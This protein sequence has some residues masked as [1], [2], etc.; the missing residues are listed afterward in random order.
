MFAKRDGIMLHE[1]LMVLTKCY[2]ES[3]KPFEKRQTRDSKT[4]CLELLAKVYCNKITLNDNQINNNC[5]IKMKDYPENY[6]LWA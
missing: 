1:P 2:I 5:S 4:Q 6:L 3:I